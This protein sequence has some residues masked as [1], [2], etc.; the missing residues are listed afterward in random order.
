MGK[1]LIYWIN[2]QEIECKLKS[3]PS[4]NIYVNLFNKQHI[5][6]ALAAHADLAMHKCIAKNA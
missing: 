1:Q 6:D 2:G 5:T 3:V 4:S